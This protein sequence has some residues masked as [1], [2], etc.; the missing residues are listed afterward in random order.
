MSKAERQRVKGET[1][2]QKERERERK[3]K[4]MLAAWHVK[5]KL[6]VVCVCVCPRDIR[7]LLQ[8]SQWPGFQGALEMVPWPARLKAKQAAAMQ[9]VSRSLLY[10]S[11]HRLAHMRFM[12]RT[13]SDVN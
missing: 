5:L 7:R 2:R 4:Y 11:W 1:P 9:C 10:T 6:A 12:E 13:T 8:L 3:K